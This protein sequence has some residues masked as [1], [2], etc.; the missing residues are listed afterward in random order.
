M[1]FELPDLIEN[2][3]RQK[4]NLHGAI[5][6]TLSDF[7]PWISESSMT[8]FPGYTDHG[9]DH[10]N[11][12]LST[13]V[14]LMTDRSREIFTPEDAYVLTIAILLHDCAMHLSQD[15]FVSLI[16]EKYNTNLIAGLD[17]ESWDE[18]WDSFLS[19]VSRYDSKK[20]ISIFG[21]NS[22]INTKRIDIKNLTQKDNLLIGEFIRKHH[23][24]LAHE[25]AIHG[26]PG[27]V[28]EVER[29][30]ITEV[31]HD[32]SDI[33]GLI[34]RSHGMGL[35]TALDYLQHNYNIRTY[36][37]VHSVFIMGLLR[38]S[39]YI[40]VENERAN[41]Q[42]LK[43]KKLVSPISKEEWKTHFSI[44]NIDSANED[45]ESLFIDSLPTSIDIY[46][47]LR[48][49][50]KD[51]QRE[52]D[53]TWAVLGEVYGRYETLNE[54][55]YS[56]RRIKSNLT[57]TPKLRESLSFIPGEF[58][59][60]TA[61]AELLQLLVTPLYGNKPKF[62]IRELIQNS[63]DACRE[64]D[65]YIKH[66]KLSALDFYEQETDVLIKVFIKND[67]Y[68]MSITDKG[69][70]MNINTISNYFLR[71]GASFRNSDSWKKEFADDEGHS[72]VLRGGRFGVGALACFLLG[73]RIEI[74][75]RHINQNK[76]RAV[77]FAALLN[78]D[79]LEL[80]YVTAPI[81]TKITIK[82][83]QNAIKNILPSNSDIDRYMENNDLDYVFSS[84]F[85]YLLESPSLKIKFELQQSM[86]YQA[87][88]LLPLP[89]AELLND[90]VRIHDENYED[91]QWTYESNCFDSY[92]N[93][94][95]CN[96]IIV[97]H[98]GRDQIDIDSIYSMK[99]PIMSIFDPDGVFPLNL[100]RTSCSEDEFTFDQELI[101]SI[102]KDFVAH[103][104]VNTPNI[105]NLEA[106]ELVE[107]IDKISS[108]KCFNE[109]YRLRSKEWV[110]YVFLAD[111]LTFF[112]IDTFNKI[113][114]NRVLAYKSKKNFSK[115][116]KEKLDE[117][118]MHCI[119]N[120]TNSDKDSLSWFRFALSREK[121]HL[122]TPFRYL[123]IKY[124]RI[125][126]KKITYKLA[127]QPGRVKRE[128]V[129]NIYTL[130]E[131]EEWVLISNNPNNTGISRLLS[132]AKRN[133]DKEN[134]YSE[135]VEFYL[136]E[137]KWNENSPYHWDSNK[138]SSIYSKIWMRILDQAV[139][140][141]DEDKRKKKLERAYSTLS[142]Y[143]TR[144]LY[145]KSTKERR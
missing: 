41:K 112:D 74:T 115:T 107:K 18:L 86:E 78:S 91:I 139:I 131:N 4:P 27:P 3:L 20:L 117:N 73:E 128:I 79:Y 35:R 14:S 43:V 120:L 80:K 59:F 38:I 44:R 116:L 45:P 137:P 130:W 53:T 12:V 37:S 97:P 109:S 99:Q 93:S 77:N 76:N 55:G 56:L 145:L 118:T 83:N 51:I 82:L 21:D 98:F 135:I 52:I 9:P 16:K 48:N 15:G 134:E 66:Q 101:N 30:K 68:Y 46:L 110:P 67:D 144:N 1:E 96:G 95:A 28:N 39:D 33:S 6:T 24:R 26:V 143:I 141:Y 108:A 136:N 114:T 129:N 2:K 32:F 25:I 126:L 75:T 70:G 42:L 11:Q 127:I 50:F 71:A 22:P 58:K 103:L 142:E 106:N 5:L 87:K 133:Y 47:K 13:S 81:G 10:I 36:Q 17:T 34:A 49:L 54:L 124:G 60:V 94:F 100:Q 92:S 89:N 64:R 19:D 125:L 85:H 8:F 72:K 132:E 102:V 63:I 88:N 23:A 119:F 65:V 105:Y 31:S 123:D 61:E 121:Y 84:F 57:D 29:I 7:N 113:G 40:Q 62:G 111:G 90:W 140:P 104:L 122:Y 138:Y 69:I